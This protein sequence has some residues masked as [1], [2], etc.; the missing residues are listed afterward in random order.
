MIDVLREDR[1]VAVIRAKAVPRARD[2][3]EALLAAGIRC[4]EFTLTID[5][6]LTAIEAA[7]RTEAIVGAGTVLSDEQARGAESAGARFLVSPVS[8]EQV[9]KAAAARGLPLIAGALSP[10]EILA[11]HRAGAA[12]V[13]VFP[14]RLGGPDYIR[15]L[16]A[17]LPFV[18]LV[19]SGGINERNATAFLEAGALAVSSGTST[20]P[21][22]LVESADHSAI[23]RRARAL[24]RAIRPAA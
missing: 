4:V 23:E 10:S 18:E 19:P 20:V 17:P 12:A 2:L 14:A 13:K 6:A 7:A 16:K 3:V 5:D 21:A 15:D 24:V 9:L 1:V 22:S 11:A 8:D